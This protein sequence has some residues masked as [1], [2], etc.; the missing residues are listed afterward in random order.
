MALTASGGVDA[1]QS[2]AA[3]ADLMG[4]GDTVV[5]TSTLTV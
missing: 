5:V 3:Y 4:A 1:A 2:P